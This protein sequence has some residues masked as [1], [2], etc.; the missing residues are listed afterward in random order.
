MPHKIEIPDATYSDVEAML[1]Q[2]GGGNV[3]DFVNS[4]LQKRLFFETVAKI[5]QQNQDASPEELQQAI[6]DAV[7]AVRT[8][9]SAEQEENPG[10]DRS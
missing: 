2:R 5:Q 10:A 9:R 1:A 3:A 6:D 4:T 7:T 8:D